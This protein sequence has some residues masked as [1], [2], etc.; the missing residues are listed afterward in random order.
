MVISGY[1]WVVMYKNKDKGKIIGREV[2][3]DILNDLLSSDQSELLAIIGRR[4][5]GKTYLIK[6][7]LEVSPH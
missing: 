2:E 3:L 4:R 1:I 7:G 6:H 5:V